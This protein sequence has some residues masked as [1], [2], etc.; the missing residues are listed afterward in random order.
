M[1]DFSLDDPSFYEDFLVE[2]GEHFEQIE[3]N[4]L[5]LE[6]APGDLEILNSIF[7]SV[8]TIKGAS[9]FLGL[10]KV[11]ALAHIG[12]NVLDDLRKGRMLVSPLVMELLFETED[13]LKILV[14][15]VSV[16][17]H[18]QGTMVDPDTTDLIARLEALKGGGRT[19][20]PAGLGA[21]P[22]GPMDASGASM[23][24][25]PSRLPDRRRTGR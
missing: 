16:S 1:S 22:S 25:K 20:A 21:V 9:G 12:E 10:A 8:H 17:L 4:F 5:T 13:V 24:G 23:G 7:R 11:Q 6:G 19:A 15:D 14:Q 3:Q 18:K 2:A